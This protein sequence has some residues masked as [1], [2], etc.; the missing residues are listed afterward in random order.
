MKG[1]G[2][3]LI[4][5][6]VVVLIIGILAA[7][8]VAN[9]GVLVEKV[10][11]ARVMN[12]GH[13]VRHAAERYYYVQ[14]HYPVERKHLD[15][16]WKCP[17]GFD[18]IWREDGISKITFRRSGKYTIIFSFIRREP[19]YTNMTYCVAPKGDKYRNKLCKAVAGNGEDISPNDKMYSRYRIK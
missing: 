3:S 12:L 5:L 9:Y 10:Y 19:P 4:E 16:T 8:A 18:C 14:G 17:K 7:V 13:A 2:F 11:S 15:I 6:L 1:N